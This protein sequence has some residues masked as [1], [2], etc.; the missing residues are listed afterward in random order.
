MQFHTYSCLIRTMIT[1]NMLNYQACDFCHFDILF[2]AKA[3]A[4]KFAI[5][6]CADKLPR[7]LG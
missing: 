4:V 3:L 7:P 6:N 5:A 2:G 1:N